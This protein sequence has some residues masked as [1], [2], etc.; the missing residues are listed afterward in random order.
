M[1]GRF[2]RRKRFARRFAM[3]SRRVLLRGM[4]RLRR[5]VENDQLLLV[6]LAIA[7]GALGALG[8]IGF[9]ET[10]AQIQKFALGSAAAH[11]LP[12]LRELPW[13]RILL[14]TTLG[15]L[16][17]G[18][19]T[20]YVVPG[21]RAP[22]VPDVMEAAALKG[23]RLDLKT[24]ILGAMVNAASIGVGGSVGREGAVIHL[25]STFGSWLGQRMRLPPAML[26]TA[27]GCGV[28]SAVAASFNAPIAG[29]FFAL[30]VVVGNYALSTFAPLV[31]ASVVG[32]VIS[33]LYYGDFPSF[34]LPHYQIGSPWEFFAFGLLGLICAAVSV[35]FMT[36]AEYVESRFERYEV[37]RWLRPVV[38]GL[39]L[40][41]IAL[42]YP[43]VLGVGYGSIDNAL[44]GNLPMGLM[45][46]LVVAK[47][48]ATAICIGSGFGGGDFSAS[49][50]MG[51]MT[52]GAF[53]T[54]ATE[55]FPGLASTH[56]AYALVGMGAVA[57]PVL[58]APITTILI[59]FE[60]TGD[61]AMTL[62]VM[63]GVVIAALIVNETFGRS[64]YVMKLEHRGINL[65]A[66]RELGIMRSIPIADL[67]RTQLATVRPGAGLAEVVDALRGAPYGLVFVTDE[68]NI[69]SGVITVTDLAPVADSVAQPGLPV[70]AADVA[71]LKPLVLE[72]EDNPHRALRLMETSPWSHLPVVQDKASMRLVGVVDIHDLVLAYHRA[73]LQ[74]RAEERGE[75]P[76][77]KPRRHARIL[78]APVVPSASSPAAVGLSGR[79][80]INKQ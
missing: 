10:Y 37:P 71:S 77:R 21:G 19:F 18:L 70:I 50:F 3:P 4:I 9:R 13:W 25:G 76:R 78:P 6:L 29:V 43:N 31:V 52:G 57:G 75:R 22:G 61:Y 2:A 14:A 12:V 59:I 65:K 1:A 7:I 49:L 60:M 15:G 47:L 5:M 23:G 67:M 33:R 64:M 58:G 30:E 28:A 44:F 53:G 68:D 63:I 40:G 41:L 73:L 56:G 16:V 20:K 36:A 38:G 45:V 55:A 35:I 39:L 42:F 32:T 79:L 48:A 62:A 11:L 66:G 80:P 69:L 17:I 26:R 34:M 24:T 27:V 8:V 51:A 74:A 54:L 72:A 46:A